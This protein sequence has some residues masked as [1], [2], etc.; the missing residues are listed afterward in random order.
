MDRLTHVP[1]SWSLDA[2][3]APWGDRPAFADFLR[4]YLTDHPDTEFVINETPDDE[5]AGLPYQDLFTMDKVLRE[6]ASAPDAD[7]QFACEQFTRLDALLQNATPETLCEFYTIA[8]FVGTSYRKQPLAKL[9][10][11]IAT[12]DRE[13][14]YAVAR[15]LTD[16]A[17]DRTAV[18]VGISLL[19]LFPERDH[20]ELLMFLGWHEDLV[21]YVAA[22]L[23]CI[24]SDPELLL[25]ELAKRD[26]GW[27]RIDIIIDYLQYTQ[28]PEI[29]A[30]LLRDGYRLDMPIKYV[31]CECAIGGDL[32]GALADQTPDD[33]LLYGAA[34]ILAEMM[35]PGGPCDC[36]SGFPDAIPATQQLLAHLRQK[37]RLPLQVLCHVNEMRAFLQRVAEEAHYATWLPVREALLA[38][39]D[40]LLPAAEIVPCLLEALHGN[41]RLLNYYAQRMAPAFALDTWEVSFAGLLQGK[42]TWQEVTATTDPARIARVLEWANTNLPCEVMTG[43]PLRE[44]AMP[45]PGSS[46]WALWSVLGMLPHV[47]GQGWRFIRAG[48]LCPFI[49]MRNAAVRALTAW[50]RTDWPEEARDVIATAL[51]VEPNPDLADRLRSLLEPTPLPPPE[52]SQ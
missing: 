43:P 36:L 13:R 52:S 35:S 28:R 5:V 29:K 47:P 2:L 38:E 25:W 24:M 1:P 18:T 26:V 30:W 11:A 48:L 7:Q 32:L 34:E 42:N 9:A 16:K 49:Q 23:P 50:S 8:A 19:S 15:W 21:E 4:G 45:V 20:R 51:A 10:G 6:M 41:D 37:P 44:L 17:A 40:A 39:T 14:L 3:P 33:A 12:L 46:H 22:V 27:A 31:A